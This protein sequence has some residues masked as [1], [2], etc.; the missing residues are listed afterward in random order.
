MKNN[1][2]HS[3]RQEPV[4]HIHRLSFAG[5]QSRVCQAS[6]KPKNKASQ[7]WSRLVKPKSFSGKQPRR[8]TPVFRVFRVFRGSNL[9]RSGTISAPVF[10]PSFHGTVANQ[11]LTIRNCTIATEEMGDG[12]WERRRLAGHFLP[13]GCA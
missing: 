11:R 4:Y 13:S 2:I 8:I 10:A 9:L 6:V 5:S 1:A 7:T 3:G 12:R